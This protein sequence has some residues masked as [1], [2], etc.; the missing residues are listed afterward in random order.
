MRSLIFPLLWVELHWQ[1]RKQKVISPL[2]TTAISSVWLL[3]RT[4]P[5]TLGMFIRT[6]LQEG[7]ESKGHLT[8]FMSADDWIQSTILCAIS[9]LDNPFIRLLKSVPKQ[10]VTNWAWLVASE[11]S[12]W[13]HILIVLFTHNFNFLT[14]TTTHEII[15]Q[16]FAMNI[17]EGPGGGS[18]QE[19]PFI[20]PVLWGSPGDS[21]V[22]SADC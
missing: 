11:F 19:W 15:M 7:G 1:K 8:V 14:Y 22:L 4:H 21:D 2:P 20:I 10:S 6:L 13:T 9:H 18:Y 16:C 17:V 5:L 12:E 3:M